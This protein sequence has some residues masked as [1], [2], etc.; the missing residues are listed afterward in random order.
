MAVTVLL[1]ATPV[2]ANLI[3]NGDFET[4]SLAPWVSA[5]MPGV[6]ITTDAHTG[7]S[8]AKLN[9][10]N[11]ILDQTVAIIG[12]STYLLDFWA[13]ADGAGLLT[14]SL[15]GTAG[16]PPLFSPGTLGATYAH[17]FYTIKPLMAGSLTFS[18]GTTG[19]AFIDDVNLVNLTPVPEPTTMIAGALLL[20]PIALST[21]RG[22]R[23]K[24]TA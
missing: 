8:A 22:L 21:L 4:G 9:P 15:D 20:L 11:T 16:F 17:Y 18:W 14:I 3:A 5:G 24:R 2:Q 7:V 19:S 12:G 10:S 23:R 1:G 13:K 6:T